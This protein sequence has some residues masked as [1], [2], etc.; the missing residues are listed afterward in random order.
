MTDQQQPDNIIS[1][2]NVAILVNNL[3]VIATGHER[4]SRMPVTR[5]MMT[6]A[7]DVIEAQREE[8]AQLRGDLAKSEEF[9]ARLNQHCEWLEG[10]CAKLQMQRVSAKWDGGPSQDGE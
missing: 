4:L 1:P 2:S 7:A 6:E 9:F 10:E 5:K 8:I 3:R